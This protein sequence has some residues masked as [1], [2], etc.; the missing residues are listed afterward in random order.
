MISETFFVICSLRNKWADQG[1]GG[2]YD[3]N[4]LYT[5][6]KEVK[7]GGTGRGEISAVTLKNYI[8]FKSKLSN[9]KFSLGLI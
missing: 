8:A 3:Q 1:G 6:L 4:A 5:I 2:E 9:V 7:R